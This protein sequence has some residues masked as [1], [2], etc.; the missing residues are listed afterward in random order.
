MRMSPIATA[1]ACVVGLASQVAQAQRHDEQ[2]QAELAKALS[3]S[4]IPLEKAVQVGEKEGKAISAKFEIASGKLALLVYTV[5]GDKF[6]EVRVD[7]QT[8]KL[9][10][11]RNIEAAADL[12]EARTQSEAMAKAKRSLRSAIE[13]AV[14]TNKGFRAVS[15]IPGIQKRHPVAEVTLLRGSQLKTVSERLD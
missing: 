12:A 8:G 1:L 2:E 9:D 7:H 14:S 13:K 4:K 5:K 15:A 11:A 3:E 10:K 6:S